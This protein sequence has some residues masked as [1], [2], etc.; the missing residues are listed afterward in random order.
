MLPVR[1]LRLAH[2]LSHSGL[3][4][5][6]EIGRE[7]DPRLRHV[8]P[9]GVVELRCEVDCGPGQLC[10]LVSGPGVAPA[11]LNHPIAA[12]DVEALLTVPSCR[13]GQAMEAVLARKE[14]SWRK[15]ERP[16]LHHALSIHATLDL[17]GPGLQSLARRLVPGERVPRLDLNAVD[18]DSEPPATC[19]LACEKSV[20]DHPEMGV[21]P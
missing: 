13:A 11:T 10:V 15:H 18:C 20:E 6:S 9:Q 8:Y 1:S 12:I 5:F 4:L 14:L 21:Q 7:E 17:E 3:E 2:E 16:E 19:H